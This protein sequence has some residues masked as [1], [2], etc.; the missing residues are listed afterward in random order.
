MYVPAPHT[1]ERLGRVLV[2]CLLDWNVDTKVSTITLD[3]CSTNDSMIRFIQSKLL[4]QYLIS[5]GALIHM[6]CSAHILNLIVKEGLDM[7]EEGIENIRD[8]VLYWSATSKRL[9][10]FEETVRQ[11]RLNS[12]NRLVMDC[13]TR[14][15]S[16]FK[17]LSVAIPYKEVFYRLKQR[18][19]QYN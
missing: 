11:L 8:S 14:W 16:T 6:R 17:M 19:A 13:P 4:S 2:D 10:F 9:E 3:N 7:V 1:A 5:E 12:E 18:D 15:N